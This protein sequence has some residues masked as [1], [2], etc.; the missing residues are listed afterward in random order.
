M[1][2]IKTFTVIFILLF[3][4]IIPA[5]PHFFDNTEPD[6]LI[7]QIISEMDNTELLGQVML[8]GYY[9]LDPSEDILHW[10]SNKKIGGVKI[11]GWNVSNLERLGKSISLMQ[12]TAAET[13]L[14]IPLFIATDQEGGWVRHIKGNTSITPGNMSIGATSMPEDAYK[15]GKYIGNELKTIGINMNFAPTVDI[16]TNPDAVVIGPRA[17]SSDPVSTASLSTSFF[18][19][20]ESTSV[21]STAKHFPGHGSASGDSHGMLPIVNADFETLW[22]RE[23]LPYRF[24]IKRGIPA[25][26]SGHISFPEIT[27]EN[28]AASGSKYFLTTL[29]REQMGFEGIIITDDMIMEGADSTSIGIDKICYNSL[30]AG[31]NIIM[32]SRTAKTYQKI[33]DYLY[34]KLQTE[35]SFKEIIKSSVSRILKTKFT[36]LKREDSV[37]LYPDIKKITNDIPNSTGSEFF[38]DQAFRSVSILRNT[39]LP[40][41]I[42]NDSNI[43]IAAPYKTFLSEGKKQIKNA[44]TYY[45][46]FIPDKES[47]SKFLMDFQLKA[48]SFD[49]VILCLVNDFSLE[50][51]KTLKTLPVKVSVISAL[52]PIYIQEQEW[53]TSAVAV[54]GT[55]YESFMAGFSALLGQY[56]PTG[57]VPIESL[58]IKDSN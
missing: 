43:L 53:I 56:S 26:M 9:G 33:W 16:Y 32:I 23:L 14:G 5:L 42:E 27:G 29:L 25:I 41:I 28:I 21:I 10:I 20:Q 22:N 35:N 15:T 4:S 19:G 34:N 55:G 24:L 40:I 49:R 47:E 17:F 38:L 11:F 50:M 13:P 39:D 18:Q 12:K 37:S 52:S 31:N 8:L 58:K 57:I 30:V 46:P 6:I 1:N 48:Q 3:P 44:S 36:Y 2:K 7:Q 54:Y 45:F 51:L